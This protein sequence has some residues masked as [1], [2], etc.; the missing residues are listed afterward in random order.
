METTRVSANRLNASGVPLGSSARLIEQ[1][2]PTSDGSRLDYTLAVT[3]PEYLSEPARFTRSWVYR[4][5]ER[6]LPFECKE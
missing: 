6:V 1:F 2:T 5:G 3:D 4:P